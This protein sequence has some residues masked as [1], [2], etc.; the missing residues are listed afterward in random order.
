MFVLRLQI[1]YVIQ[2][3]QCIDTSV[4][5]GMA[6]LQRISPEVELFSFFR[7][8]STHSHLSSNNNLMVSALN[9]FNCMFH[10]TCICHCVPNAWLFDFV[11]GVF[12]LL[13]PFPP[14]IFCIISLGLP[15]KLWN[16]SGDLI[17][18]E[19][20]NNRTGLC[21]CRS[22]LLFCCDWRDQNSFS[23]SIKHCILL[24]VHIFSH[25]IYHIF[26]YD[27][28]DNVSDVLDDSM[29][30]PGRTFDDDDLINDV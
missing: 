3:Q 1:P 5:H 17:I 6:S 4:L 12:P 26:Y 10:T 8:L 28:L 16:C 2:I 19:I 13:A 27:R 20:H 22:F 18:S 24:I 25:I 15:I 21:S 11:A 7:G 14:S 29:P 9:K 23:H 30:A